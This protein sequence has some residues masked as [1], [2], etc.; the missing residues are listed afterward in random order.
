MTIH[1]LEQQIDE[2]VRTKRHCGG[3]A[4]ELEQRVRERTAGLAEANQ[5]LRAEIAERERAEAAL[6]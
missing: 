5:A 2:R 1:A 3:R 4:I 6:R